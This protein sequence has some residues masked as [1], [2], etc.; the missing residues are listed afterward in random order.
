MTPRPRAAIVGVSGPRLTAE[1]TAL[2]RAAPPLG[3]I[4]FARNVVD[5]DQLRALNAE[6]RDLL[7]AEAPI[8]VDQEGGRVARLR[9]PHWPAFAPAAAFSGGP[10]EVARAHAALLGLACAGVGFDVVCAPVL[11]L[12]LPGAHDIIGDRSFGADP[13]EVAR[14]GLATIEGLQEAGCIPVIKHIPGHGRALADSHFELPRVAASRDDLALDCAPFA[15]LAGAGAWAMTA[16]ILYEALDAARP[17]TLSPAVIARVIRGAIGFEGVLVSDDLCMK[18]LR[19]DPGALAAEAIDAGCDL[20]LHCSGVLEETAAC[21]AG[22]P[23]LS[24]GAVAR[25]EAARGA[26]L[27]RR[28][29]LDPVTLAATRDAWLVQAA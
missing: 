11:D 15:A 29:P 14:L 9:P 12:R 26:M 25:L 16:H 6:L 22:C 27:A 7:G 17:A 21:L 3:A 23:A 20:V 4:L 5:P 2:F 10:A 19:G 8:L 13:A 28:R 1:E 18:A 24:K